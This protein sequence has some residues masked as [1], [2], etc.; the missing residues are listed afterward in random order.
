MTKEIDVLLEEIREACATNLTVDWS[1]KDPGPEFVYIMDL[2]EIY[3]KENKW[4][5]KQTTNQQKRG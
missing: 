4:A 1:D 5:S 3:K 2:M